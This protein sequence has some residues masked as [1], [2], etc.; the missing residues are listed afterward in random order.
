MMTAKVP[1]LIEGVHKS[2]KSLHLPF[3][4]AFVVLESPVLVR[5]LVVDDPII[6]ILC[7][8]W[9]VPLIYDRIVEAI[10]HLDFKWSIKVYFTLR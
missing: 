4:R 7:S 2:F 5:F 3:G 10:F 1:D 6:P 8:F 9:S